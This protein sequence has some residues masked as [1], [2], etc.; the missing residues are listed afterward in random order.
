MYH[1]INLDMLVMTDNPPEPTLEAL[2]LF[3]ME[4]TQCIANVAV[5]PMV[6]QCNAMPFTSP[7]TAIICANSTSTPPTSTAPPVS[8]APTEHT[9]PSTQTTETYSDYSVERSDKPIS[10]VIKMSTKSPRIARI[11]IEPGH[12]YPRY[13]SHNDSWLS[14]RK[15]GRHYFYDSV[16]NHRGETNRPVRFRVTTG[17]LETLYTAYNYIRCANKLA[18][19]TRDNRRAGSHIWLTRS[20]AQ[21]IRK[22]RNGS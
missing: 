14:V 16:H 22:H 10:K 7:P 3:L 1:R 15:N 2:T 17:E 20:E 9:P 21:E 6:A 5:T 8:V 11:T 19:G 13:Y 12:S 4:Q 18:M